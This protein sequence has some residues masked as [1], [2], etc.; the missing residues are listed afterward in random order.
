MQ[1]STEATDSPVRKHSNVTVYSEVEPEER[2]ECN[3]NRRLCDESKRLDVQNCLN[4]SLNVITL[5][6][7]GDNPPTAEN[8]GLNEVRACRSA[9]H[10]RPRRINLSDS[11]TEI[12]GA[13]ASEAG[14]L[15]ARFAG[16]RCVQRALLPG[17]S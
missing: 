4:I 15:L 7:I 12:G 2:R 3:A 5:A 14:P 9:T 11:R 6:I 16:G 13:H 1:C 10:Q 8:S 17:T